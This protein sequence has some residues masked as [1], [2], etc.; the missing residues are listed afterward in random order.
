MRSLTPYT[1]VILR[2]YYGKGYN[3]TFT[4][5]SRAVTTNTKCLYLYP[6][7]SLQPADIPFIDIPSADILS[8]D[9]PFADI[10]SANQTKILKENKVDIIKDFLI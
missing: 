8:A 5:L 7:P 1:R 10:P 9:I 3:F 6:P 4:L 2:S